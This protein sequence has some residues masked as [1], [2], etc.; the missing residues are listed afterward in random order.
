MA[1]HQ[2]WVHRP[3][4]KWVKLHWAKIDQW[5]GKISNIVMP[6]SLVK[7]RIKPRY[8]MIIIKCYQNCSKSSTEKELTCTQVIFHQETVSMRREFQLLN[9]IINLKDQKDQV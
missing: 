7:Y 3:K 1:N 2:K 6:S 5:I 4:E 9:L 8:K